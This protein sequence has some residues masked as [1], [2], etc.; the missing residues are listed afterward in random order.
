MDFRLLNATPNLGMKA[1]RGLGINY[2]QPINQRFRAGWNEVVDRLKSYA[3]AV[4]TGK[5]SRKKEDPI[6]GPWWQRD[7]AGIRGGSSQGAGV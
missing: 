6:R 4:G 2:V 5:E 7:D 3:E 1:L